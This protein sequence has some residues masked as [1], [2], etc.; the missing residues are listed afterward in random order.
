[1]G[2]IPRNVGAGVNLLGSWDCPLQVAKLLFF[3]SSVF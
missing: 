1:M 2:K 3:N